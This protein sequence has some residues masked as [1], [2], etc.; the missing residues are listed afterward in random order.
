MLQR[1]GYCVSRSVNGIRKFHNCWALLDS[2]ADSQIDINWF[3]G[4][5]ID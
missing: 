4:R 1:Q 5:V 2:L 3:A